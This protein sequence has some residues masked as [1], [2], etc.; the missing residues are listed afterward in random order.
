MTITAAKITAPTEEGFMMKMAGTVTDT[1][2]FDAKIE[3]TSPAKM[4]AGGVELGEVKLPPIT[5][6][7]GSGAT[8]DSVA[9][10]RVTNKEEFGKF[11]KKM[12]SSESF[13]W[14]ISG[15]ASVHAMGLTLSGIKVV[16]ELPLKGMNNFPNVQIKSFDLPAN[17]PAGGI[18]LKVETGLENPSPIGMEV[19]DMYFDMTYNGTKVGEVVSYQVTLESGMNAL[20]MAGRLVPQSNQADLDTLSEMMS[21]YLKG[22]TADVSVVGTNVRPNNNTE[23]ISWLLAGFKG[24][25]MTVPFPGAKGLKL[26]KKVEIG[27]MSMVVTPETAYRPLSSGSGIVAHFKMPFNFP[28]S[29]KRLT[30]TITVSNGDGMKFATMDVPWSPATGDTTT[31]RIIT[32]FSNVRMVVNQGAEHIFSNFVL[33]LTSTRGQN[34]IMDVEAGAVASTAV[35]D[36]T[37]SGMKFDDS[38]PLKGM[39]GLR[40]VN[41]AIQQIIVRG[42]TR[43][44]LQIDIVVSMPNPS[45]VGISCGRVQFECFYEQQRMGIVVIPNMVMNPGSNNIQSTMYFAPKGSA[46]IASGRRLMSGY[47]AGR[48]AQVGL[49]ATPATVTPI[50]SL[51]AALSSIKI[52]TVM[53]G[54]RGVQ[55]MRGAFFGIDIK[56]IFTQ[57]ATARFDAYNPLDAT[58]RFLEMDCQMTYK[59]KSVGTIKHNMRN[60]PLII[61]PKSVVSSQRF[62]LKIQLSLAAIKMFVEA[63]KD[64]LYVDV[65]AVVVTAVGG[66]EMTIDFAQDGI[67]SRFG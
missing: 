58:I 38:V 1:G 43:E 11:A 64:T 7:A 20:T 2:P 13:V 39:N 55:V 62:P 9:P 28:L 31:G 54:L 44:A 34:M 8:L 22:E 52:Q 33:A 5:A 4:L 29:M 16:K 18:Q 47:L 32:S 50:Q 17:D 23:P 36:L 49:S 65:R 53:P 12:L 6:K 63:L 27:T 25:T 59:G 35:G 57:T 40:D 21:K 46:A 24:T 19:G 45:N 15:E 41:I 67:W 26:V 10:F 56:T 60:N 61:P 66:Y 42:G 37:I 14:T 30:Q 51:K 3:F 48:S